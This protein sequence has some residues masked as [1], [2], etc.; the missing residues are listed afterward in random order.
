LLLFPAPACLLVCVLNDKHV[1]QVA[2]ADEGLLSSM[3]AGQVL[4]IHSTIS[5]R[6]AKEVAAAAAAK[7]IECLDAPVTA[8][9]H[10][11]RHEGKST[12]F[13]G[14]SRPA[15]ERTLPIFRAMASHVD[16]LGPVGSGE[17]AKLCNNLMNYCNTLC[18]LEAARL[19]EAY[20]IPEDKM[21]A[22]ALHGSGSSWS[23][24]E[25]GFIDRMRAQHT[26]ADD[27]AALLEFLAKD[28]ELATQAAADAHLE[29]PLAERMQAILRSSF[30]QRWQLLRSRRPR[31]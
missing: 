9:S 14:G 7:G 27:E 6:L 17:V 22:L 16:L 31:T 13:V 3:K 26:L 8:P 28:V 15:F 2:L 1:V 10:H 25:W 29:L 18:S 20:G 4:V 21:V 5:P 24:Q 23:L 19:A 12:L 11:A 30:Q